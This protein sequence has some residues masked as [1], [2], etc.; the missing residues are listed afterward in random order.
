MLRNNAD[1]RRRS[2]FELGLPVPS[3]RINGVRLYDIL[4]VFSIIRKWNCATLF[5]LNYWV[6]SRFSPLS[7]ISEIE[8][9]PIK[10]LAKYKHVK[11]NTASRSKLIDLTKKFHFVPSVVK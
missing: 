10:I 1:A 11:L 2:Y 8:D 3:V 9:P 4:D 6:F 7:K 5:L